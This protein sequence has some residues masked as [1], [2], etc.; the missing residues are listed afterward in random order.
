MNSKTTLFSKISNNIFLLI[1]IFCIFFLWTNI[2]TKNIYTSF[3]CSLIVLI[4]FSIIYYPIKIINSKNKK[5][6]NNNFQ[7]K[8]Y[9]KIQ[10]LFGKNEKIIKFII[11]LFK[12]K[13]HSKI[14][15]THFVITEDNLDIFFFFNNILTEK[16]IN[17]VYKNTI[18]QNIKIF[19]LEFEKAITKLK[20]YNLEIIDFENIYNNCRNNNCYLD[21]NI[22]IKKTTKYS[23]KN[24]LC[25]VFSKGRSKSYFWL[26]LLLLFSSLFTPYNIYYIVFSSILFILAIY[27]KFNKHFNQ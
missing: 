10:F 22:E 8:D 27:S 6:K 3:V 21:F 25:I 14:T 19:C 26:A 7:K 2:Y 1:S 17:L 15:N 23:F 5:K 9:T 18:N 20:N 4:A 12:I 13:N 16:E 24:I 11:E